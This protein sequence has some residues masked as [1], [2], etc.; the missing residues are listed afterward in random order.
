MNIPLGLAERG[1]V[2]LLGRGHLVEFAL[3][4]R[5]A[6]EQNVENQRRVPRNTRLLLI[7]TLLQTAYVALL[8]VRVLGRDAQLRVL[9]HAH[10][11]VGNVPTR[12]HLISL[13]LS[14]K[15]RTAP[16]PSIKVNSLSRARE[17]SKISSEPTLV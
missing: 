9:P 3:L 7:I 12:D 4:D 10:L 1:L 5:A 15:E 13:P 8:A 2:Q 6:D 14:R 17:Q 11:L 16:A